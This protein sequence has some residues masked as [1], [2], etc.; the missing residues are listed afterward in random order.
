MKYTQRVVAWIKARRTERERAENERI[1]RVSRE[2]V[3]LREFNGE[4]YIALDKIPIVSVS[5]HIKEAIPAL[6]EVRQTLLSY[7]NQSK[8]VQQ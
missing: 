5:S 3:Q 4:I 8:S 7:I 2:R 1:I 6:E